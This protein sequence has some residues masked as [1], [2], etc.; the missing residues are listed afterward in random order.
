MKQSIDSAQIPRTSRTCAVRAAALFALVLCACACAP[1]PPQRDAV[2]ARA[3]VAAE[4]RPSPNFDHR[5]ANFVILHHT[6]NNT[7][8]TALRVLTDRARRVSSHYLVARDGKIFRLVDDRQRAWHAGASYWGGHR[9]IN[10]ASIGI[11]LDNNGAEPYAEPMIAS[12]LVLLADLKTRYAIPAANFIG[13]SD[14]APGRKVDPSAFFP[15]KRLSEQGFG[16]WCDPPYPAVPAEIDTSLL[17]QAFG[18]SVWNLD[19]AIA[20]FKLHFVPDD[21]LPQMTEKD[22]SVLYCLV[23]QKQSLAAQ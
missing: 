3:G 15:W 10:S 7:A 20:S 22:R 16:L 19:A 6:S 1:L 21:P 8:E 18:Y 5:R 9:D 4:D 11:E 17:L 2:E 23:L 13:H 14:V 12:L